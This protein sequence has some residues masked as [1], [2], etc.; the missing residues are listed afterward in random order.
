MEYFFLMEKFTRLVGTSMEIVG[1]VLLM[2][3]KNFIAELYNSRYKIL[4]VFR[5]KP[6]MIE[7]PT[8]GH[9]VGVYA[10]SGYSLVTTL[11]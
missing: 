9:V 11:K 4:S 2:T 3:C 6:E 1:M 5:L 10:G 8:N 7:L